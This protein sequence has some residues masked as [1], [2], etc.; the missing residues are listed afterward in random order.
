MMKH[1]SVFRVLMMKNLSVSRFLM[2]VVGTM[3][4][5]QTYFVLNINEKFVA[6]ENISPEIQSL[7]AKEATMP[8]MRKLS[9]PNTFFDMVG[10]L[11]QKYGAEIA[12]YRP[13]MRKWCETSQSCKF[14]DYEAEMLYI[15]VREHK[16]ENVFEMAPNKGYSSHWILKALHMNDNTSRLHSFDIH[17]RS[18]PLMNEKYKPRWVFTLGDYAQFYDEGLLDMD[19][20]DFIFV[21]AL[22]EPEFARGYCKRLFANHKRKSTVVAIHDIVANE[23]GGGRESEEVYKYLAF[24]GNAQ[25]VF[26]MSRFTMPNSMY[27]PQTEKVL[28]MMNQIRA[29]MGIVKPCKGDECKRWDH[30]YL[31]FENNDA[32]T[33]FF[34]LN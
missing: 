9:N 10:E 17:D 19:K 7:P 5:C 20:F 1:L 33:I 8:F 22:H 23:M 13:I 14:G 24:A 3:L 25:N 29:A 34:T 18:V 32:P 26:T 27:K 15:L 28:P 31:Y 6:Y 2:I 12:E 16:P 4:L 30:D 11:Y 21:D